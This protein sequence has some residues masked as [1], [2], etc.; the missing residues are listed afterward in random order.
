M[1]YP[2]KKVHITQEWGVN[3][4][5]YYRFGFKTRCLS[6]LEF[7]ATVIPFPNSLSGIK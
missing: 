3:G 4:D 2:V 1:N 6:N 5:V 7:F